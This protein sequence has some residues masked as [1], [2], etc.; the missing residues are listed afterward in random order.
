MC[1]FSLYLTTMPTVSLYS[2]SGVPG[3]ELGD[4][5]KKEFLNRLPKRGEREGKHQ[6]TQVESM[7]GKGSI[8]RWVCV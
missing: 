1:F 2:D 8:G 5:F 6:N 7:V 3:R 4:S